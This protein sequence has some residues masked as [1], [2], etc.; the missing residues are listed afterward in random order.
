MNKKQPDIMNIMKNMPGAA[1]RAA[2]DPGPKI[3]C[4]KFTW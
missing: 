1:T 4:F 2:G 3:C